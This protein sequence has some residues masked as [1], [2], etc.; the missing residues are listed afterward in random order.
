MRRG[1]G[2]LGS[3]TSVTLLCNAETDSLA[4][5][6]GDQGLLVADDENVAHTRGKRVVCRILDVDNVKGTMVTLAV[7]DVS[8]TSQVT[9]TDDHDQ[10]SS[11]KGDALNDL[12]S[13]NINLDGIVSLDQRIRVT[14][15]SAIVGDQVWHGLVADSD[16]ADTAQLVLQDNIETI[17]CFSTTAIRHNKNAFESY[18]KRQ[19]Q[20]SA[21]NLNIRQ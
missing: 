7:S 13:G 20:T 17:E 6:Q 10:V 16:A 9:T 14:D 11:V 12:A 19:R 1:D 18:L 2:L 21:N 5:G 3:K 15:G 4:S 8:N